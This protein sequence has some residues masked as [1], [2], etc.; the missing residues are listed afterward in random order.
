M[1][2]DVVGRVG[3]VSLAASKPLLPLYEAVVNSVQAI[4]EAQEPNGRITIGVLRD[5][6][7][8]LSDQDA[9]FGEIVGFQII[10]NGI[11]FDDVNFRAFETS[12]TTHKARKGGKGIG[13]FLWLLAFDKAEIDSRFRE[14]NSIRS[15]TFSFV[16]EGDGVRD[17]AIQDSPEST[18]ST[19]VTLKG[20]RSKY[21]QQCPKRLETLAWHLIQH[22]LEYFIRPDCPAIVLKD[23]ASGYSISLNDQF[24]SEIASQSARDTV[25]IEDTAFHVLHVRLYS[26][27]VAE[28]HLSFCADSRVVKSERLFGKLPNLARRLHD[29]NGKAFV[30]AAYVDGKYLDEAVNSER[31]DFAIPD[32]DAELLAKTITWRIIRSAVYDSCRSFLSPYTTPIREK[33]AKRIESFVA[34][35]GPM[36]RSIVKYVEDKIDLIDPDINDDALD[37]RLYQA[38]HDLQVQLRTEG[39]KLLQKDVKDQ[40]WEDFLKQLQDYF[41]KVADINKS[42]LARYVCHRKAVLEF[43]HKQLSLAPTGKYS[44]EERIHKIIFPLRKTSDEVPID[45]HNLW[46]LDEKLVYHTFLASDKPLRTI[47]Q[48][49]SESRKEPDILVFDK[50]CAFTANSELPYGSIT[51]V[52]FKRPMRDNYTTDENPFVQVREYITAI[53]AGKARTPGGRDVPVAKDA[54]IFCYIVMDITPTLEPLAAD[55]ELEKTPDGQGYFGYKKAYKAYVEVLSYTKMVSDAKKRNAAFFDK[56][57]LTTRIGQG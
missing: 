13:R 32:D 51:I 25:K 52:E 17:M 11:G 49:G 34:S 42:D 29:E 41:D 36:Y 40:E 19:T 35:D 14:G 28:H 1:N 54:P 23:T 37:L 38:Y 57:A 22:C 46:L 21:Q 10:D 15:R 44:L 6:N 5:S 3:N 2:T 27:H 24:A 43:L 20:F 45:D 8:L 16:P 47:A 33:K 53:R 50:A 4:Q 55:F 9:T 7:N 48:V 56:L 12:D 18:L 39:K 26:T 30:Y 31:T